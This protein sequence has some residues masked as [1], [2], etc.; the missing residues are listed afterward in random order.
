DEVGDVPPAMQVKLL[1]V[2]QER[3]VR[4]LGENRSR[5]IDVRVLSATN[6]DLPAEIHAARF[7]Q[8]LYYR[9]RVVDLR[10]PPLRERA[11][12]VLPLARTF[13]AESADRTGTKVAAFSPAAA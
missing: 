11:D 8:D 9:L 7:R 2:L 5:A 6:R 12:D 13:L 3:E 10:I 1:R 4:R